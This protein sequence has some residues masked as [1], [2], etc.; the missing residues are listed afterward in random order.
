MFLRYFV[1]FLSVLCSWCLND[2]EVGVKI[3]CCVSGLVFEA[4][5]MSRERNMF[6]L[7]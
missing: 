7:R 6:S 1:R 5:C 3:S 4:A 2:V